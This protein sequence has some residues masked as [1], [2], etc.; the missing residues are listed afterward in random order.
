MCG[1]IAI[2]GYR[3]VIHDLYD[4]LLLL[5]HRGQD[6]AGIIT[7]DQQ[8]HLK[9]S[10]G[11]VRDVF[12]TKSL[13]RLKGAMGIGHVRY[14]TAG[15]SS[16]FE[17]QPFFVNTPFGMGLAHNG[18][19][20]N[21]NALRKELLEKRYR[22]LN[23]NSDSEV[24]LNMFASALRHQRPHQLTP[25]HVFGALRQV[26]RKCKGAYS[27]VSIIGGHGI[28]GFRDPHGIRPLQLGR[29]KYGM[30]YEYII[31][32][33]NTVMKALDYEFMRDIEPGEAV[34]I[35]RHNTLHTQKIRR[36]KLSPCMFEWVYLAAPD[37]TIDKVNVFKARIRMGQYLARQI[38]EAG[39][40]IDSVIPVPD[41]GRPIATGV[42]DK[43][44]VRYR[45]GLIKNRYIGRTFIMPGQ[46]MR[47][48]SLRFKLHPIEL[49][50]KNR[51][52]LLVDDS[53]VRGNT[54]RK[55]VE[56]VREAGAK[57]VYFASAAPP[58][59]CPDPYGIDLPTKEEL[60]ANEK[61]IEETCKYIGADGLFYGSI[62]D[63]RRAIRYGNK[64]IR[65]FSEG[66]FTCS[67]PTPEVTPA[68][69]RTLGMTRNTTR[70]AF[71]D[72]DTA[73]DDTDSHKMSLV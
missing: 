11:M 39:I 66:C 30:K 37:S 55:I 4:G 52:V 36:G 50:L 65:H 62:Q 8:F 23:T 27:A 9:K 73:D 47:K 2:S 20:T 48:R 49:E 51:N 17:A 10:N 21:A 42:A 34:F 45:E 6:A 32:S 19:L 38:K 57:K 33:E 12:H 28:V 41:T 72:G 68:M 3:D 29:K 63:L 7:Y 61:T 25:D 56:L 67:Y 16:E 15:C 64:E 60:I 24:L 70:S 59:R 31:A 58:I 13:S 1:V 43:L 14:P 53:I 40:A 22:H 54:S 46:G 44:R 5:Q 26:M 18:N 69:L 71:G 35:D